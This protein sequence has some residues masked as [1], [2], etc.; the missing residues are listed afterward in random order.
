MLNKIAKEFNVTYE[1]SSQVATL[2]QA[3]YATG[4]VFILPWGDMLERRAFIISLVLF[5]ATVVSTPHS[6]S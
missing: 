2:M 6:H 5:T 1:Q 4:L 3:G